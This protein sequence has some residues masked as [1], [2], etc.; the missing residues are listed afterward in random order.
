MPRSRALLLSLAC[1]V[2]LLAQ[3]PADT[4]LFSY[5]GFKANHILGDSDPALLASLD[6]LVQDSP[7]FRD[8]IADLDRRET[9]L[10]LRLVPTE[11]ATFG[12]LVVQPYPEG[13][14]VVAKVQHALVKTG[15]DA[16]EP[17]LGSILFALADISRGSAV[18]PEANQAY[19]LSREAERRMWAFQRILRKDLAG[20]ATLPKLKLAADG[21][22]LY[23][24]RYHPQR[25]LGGVR[26][27]V[28]GSPTD[29]IF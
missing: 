24:F 29:V 11:E 17:W 14:L 28:T 1:P 22:R 3:A 9:K 23:Q 12:S 8:Q 7:A 6:R 26:D 16:Q 18:Q 13:Y 19:V 5:A 4:Y 10:K 21:Q 15:F 25:T 20:A 2:L 27:P